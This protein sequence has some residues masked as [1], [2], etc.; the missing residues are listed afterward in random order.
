[1]IWLQ[2]ENDLKAYL[3][4]TISYSGTQKAAP[5]EE[6]CSARQDTTMP[7]VFLSS[8]ASEGV[9]F[10]KMDFNDTFF[11]KMMKDSYGVTRIGM[12]IGSKINLSKVLI[13]GKS[14]EK[15][16]LFI[17]VMKKQD[18]KIREI[19]LIFHSEEGV[20]FKCHIGDEGHVITYR[21]KLEEVLEDNS[22]DSP[23]SLSSHLLYIVKK[24]DEMTPEEK[25]LYT[26][27]TLHDGYTTKTID[28]TPREFLETIK[29]ICESGLKGEFDIKLEG[30]N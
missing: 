18:V 8:T 30:K 24:I 17:D 25:A 2:L 9:F 14:P 22:T 26:I 4:L 5:A 21:T 27:W 10:E 20:P 3:L 16:E 1:M 7:K 28:Y 29:T 6:L 23:D 13:T 11:F 12:N 15:S 19:G